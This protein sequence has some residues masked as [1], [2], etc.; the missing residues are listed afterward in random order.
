M[1]LIELCCTAQM[2]ILILLSQKGCIDG[3]LMQI[4]TPRE[5]DVATVT[6]YYAGHYACFGINVMACC[7]F[8]CRF[9]SFSLESPGGTGD[10]I[11]FT[12]WSLS[13]ICENFGIGEYGIGDNALTNSQFLLTPFTKVQMNQKRSNYNFS[14][15]QLRINIEMAF[16]L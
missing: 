7:D 13:R 14:L 8:N 11:A 1:F 3:W 12:R 16:G 5:D 2:L 4:E 15:S 6:S 9:T 10:S